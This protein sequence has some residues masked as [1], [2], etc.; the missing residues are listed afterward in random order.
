MI[1]LQA[2]I[3]NIREHFATVLS[4]EF[5]VELEQFPVEIPPQPEFGDLALSFCMGLARTLKQAPRKIAA[6]LIDNSPKIAGVSKLQIEGPG[7]INIFLDR[8][9]V[10]QGSLP[11]NAPAQDAGAGKIIVEHTAINP[12]K[13][14]HIGHLRNAILGDTL[15]RV[16]R[17]LGRRVEVQNY[18]DDLGVQV[19]DV[20]VGFKHL[21][22]KSLADI[23]AIAGNFDYYCWDLYAKVGDWY[24]EDPARES[25]RRQVL[26]ALEHGEGEIAQTSDY[27]VDRIVR[28]HLETMLR[29]GIKYDLLPRESSIMRLQFWT[30]AFEQFKQSGAVYYREEG[31][32]KGCWVIKTDEPTGSDDPDMQEK[33]IVRSDLTVTYV[34]KDMAYQLW[35]V[36]KLGLDFNYR[37]FYTYADGH[38]LWESTSAAGDTGAPAFGDGSGVYNLIDVRQSYTQ[39]IVVQG[40]RALGYEQAAAN[41]VHY[42]YE[43]VALTPRCAASLGFILTE[44][45]RQR[46][47]VDMSGRKGIGVKADDLIDIMCRRARAEVISRNPEMPEADCDRVARQIAVGA[48][49]YFMLKYGE[50]KL[51][52]FDIDEALAFEGE[53]GPYLQ[54]AVVRANSILKKMAARGIEF[55]RELVQ[56]DG[57]ATADKL[58]QAQ[59]DL[60]FNLLRLPMIARDSV[61]TK[62]MATL[63]KSAFNIA[64]KFHSFYHHNPIIKET[65]PEKRSLRLMIVLLFIREMTT[66]LDL[67]G[68]AIPTR[69]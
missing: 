28:C 34:G 20:V 7:Y 13:A 56:Y 45:D 65:N 62:N 49:R 31:K 5:G 33:I 37:K 12:N 10:L 6:R 24:R 27:I 21:E 51:I 30:K 59:W 60:V 58:D 69:M 25:L 19:A 64:Q 16:F 1:K 67:M 11:G 55:D 44:E 29:L 17:F 32:N 4:R 39:N 48:L 50:N 14:A 54:N 46:S 3:K 38:V 36:G 2:A 42:G 57:I 61:N 47:H 8:S 66:M 26:P 15:V 63:A 43:M 41:S 52:V 68:I 23:Q 22:K 9:A 53:T 35:K 18:I 40:L